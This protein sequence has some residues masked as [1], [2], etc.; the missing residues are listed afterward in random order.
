MS[1]IN[2]T[3]APELPVWLIIAVASLSGLLVIW[4]MYKQMR[5]SWF[6]G[7]A[8]LAITLALFNPSINAEDR[9]QLKSIVA[10]IIDNTASQKLD[11]RA[12]QSE[13]IRKSITKRIEKLTNFE[14]RELTVNDQI[15]QTTDISTALFQG[16]KSALQDVP[17]EQVAGAIF[18]TDGQVHDIPKSLESLNFHAPIHALIT[19]HE[20]E[21]DRRIT[22]VKAPR[23]GIVGNQVTLAFR[24]DEHG[25][26]NSGPLRVTILIDG[27]VYSVEQV[28]SGRVDEFDLEVPHGGK[29]IIEL[30]VEETD[31]EISTLNNRAYST[32]HGIRENLRVLLVSGEPHAGERTWR[33]LLKSDATVDLVHFTILRPPEKQDG[34]PIN[35]LSL[36]AFPT[37]E[38]FVKKIDEFDL[39]ILDRYSRRGVLPTLYFDNIARYVEDGGAVLI[40]AGPEFATRGSIAQTPLQRILPALPDGDITESG[41]RPV[42]SKLGERHPVTRDLNSRHPSPPDWSPWFRSIGTQEAD[43]DTIMTASQEEPLLVLKHAGEGR[44]ALL[45]SDH[46]WLWARGFQGGGPY[47]KLLRRL[48]HWMMKEP[49]LAE[50][51]LIARSRGDKILIRRQTLEDTLEQITL[52]TPSGKTRNITPELIKP[53]IFE[54]QYVASEMGLHQIENGKLRALTHVGP[55]NPREFANV[56]STPNLLEPLLSQTG[57]SA[58]RADNGLTPRIIPVGTNSNTSGKGWIGLRNTNATLL[59]GINTIPLFSRL[60]GLAILLLLLGAMWTREGNLLRASSSTRALP[61]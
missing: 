54:A 49:E 35:Q 43:G 23:Y 26:D 41:Y 38:L 33:N 5:G 46:V 45:L 61:V 36:I 24:V 11:G 40:A 58:I 31:N 13:E 10:L 28:N 19:G 14:I 6:R 37:R 57:G 30:R 22:I 16:L 53:G 60:L 39:I 8:W 17:P 48:V 51:N 59:R 32:L 12:D 1:T 44:V 47:V 2:I 29:T 27:E 34:T 52:I 4:G 42:I 18:I 7:T 21:Q 50:E 15:S 9:K 56:I 20:S 3:F 55:A 25:I